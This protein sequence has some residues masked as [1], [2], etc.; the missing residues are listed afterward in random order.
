[1]QRMLPK[2]LDIV[3]KYETNN[4]N[5]IAEKLGIATSYVPLP[6]DI[7]GMYIKFVA[8]QTILINRNYD[9]NERNV[10]LAHE[11]GHIFLHNNG[12]FHLLE[13]QT[14]SRKA[15]DKTEYEANK[16]AFLLIAHTCLRNS[17]LMIHSI[18]NEKFLTLDDTIQ[19]LKKF[20]QTSC[21]I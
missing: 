2:V 3:S 4:P 19:L 12:G 21:Y 10:A 9:K 16:F 1:M 18:R 17:R 13:M 15:Q 7:G 20:E 14:I 8:K 6:G 5:E 11:L